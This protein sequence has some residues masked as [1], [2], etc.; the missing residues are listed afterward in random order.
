MV[1]TVMEPLAMSE[2]RPA[3]GEPAPTGLLLCRDLIFT[4]KITGTAAHSATGCWWRAM[5][6][7]PGR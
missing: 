1:V 2:P 5:T 4:T 6:R 7:W 3:L